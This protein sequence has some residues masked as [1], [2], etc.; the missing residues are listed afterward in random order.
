M[1][2]KVYPTPDGVAAAVADVIGTTAEHET[3]VAQQAIVEKH[4]A[5]VNHRVFGM[6]APLLQ[7]FVTHG[8]GNHDGTLH[9]Q[10]STL[11]A[12][13]QMFRHEAVTGDDHLPGGQT[14]RCG[15]EHM[16]AIRLFVPMQYFTVCVY[17]RTASLRRGRES[18]GIAQRVQRKR[19]SQ[20][21]CAML[22]R[23][24]VTDLAKLVFTVGADIKPEQCALHV[25]RFF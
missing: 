6:P 10:G 8:S 3:F 23:G 15:F 20:C 19:R 5:R 14:P 13:V 24:V 16:A 17:L 7:F 12:A 1:D 18:L 9:R 22:M 11:H 4:V 21:G 25:R 2:V